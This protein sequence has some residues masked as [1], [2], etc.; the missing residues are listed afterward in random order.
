MRN[1]F[2]SKFCV[3]FKISNELFKTPMLSF[4]QGVRHPIIFYEILNF[5]SFSIKVHILEPSP[6]QFYILAWLFL[7]IKI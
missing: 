3:S 1:N 2:T 4:V 7:K 5:F 6:T